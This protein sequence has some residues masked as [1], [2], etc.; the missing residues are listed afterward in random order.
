MHL[1][2]KIRHQK[3]VN[4]GF[5][6]LQQCSISSQYGMCHLPH[7]TCLTGKPTCKSKFCQGLDQNAMICGE[8]HIQSQRPN[9]QPSISSTPTSNTFP[10]HCPKKA[11]KGSNDEPWPQF[12]LASSL[13]GQASEVGEAT[14]I[15]LLLKK[16][17]NDLKRFKK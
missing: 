11:W 6:C 16:L 14:L 15:V 17:K 1:N 5:S 13:K 8:A 4:H 2:E 10:S 9:K 12:M 3:R 7:E